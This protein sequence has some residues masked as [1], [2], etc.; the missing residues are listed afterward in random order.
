MQLVE[1]RSESAIRP[2]NYCV[3]TQSKYSAGSDVMFQMR[4]VF[5]LA[6]L[7]CRTPQG[8]QDL[9]HIKTEVYLEKLT[10]LPLR[11]SQIHGLP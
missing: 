1:P 5:V 8:G 2:T 3:P 10:L 9:R 6:G 7:V 4:R 11:L